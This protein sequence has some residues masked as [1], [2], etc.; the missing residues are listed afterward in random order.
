MVST[1]SITTTPEAQ[2][3]VE[4]IAD[5]LLIGAASIADELGVKTHAVYYLARQGR[6][7]IGRLGKNLIAS[8]AKLRRA[9]HALTS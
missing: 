8:R 3:Q 6:L 9:A 7:P 1:M 4:R 5:D 2:R